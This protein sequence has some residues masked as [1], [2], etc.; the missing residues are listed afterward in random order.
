MSAWRAWGSALLAGS[1]LLL[2]ACSSPSD[3]TVDLTKAESSLQKFIKKQWFPSLDVGTVKCPTKKIPRSKGKVSTCTVK[4]ENEP[5][6]FRVVQTNGQ[7]GIAPVRYEAIL[8]TAKAEGIVRRRY[9]DIATVSCGDGPYFV[10]KPGTE[11]HCDVTATNGRQAQ[12]FYRVLDP[13]GNP[14]WLRNT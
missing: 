8:S 7:G 14:K 5:V 10:R 11:F 4:V 2:A 1:L 6:E 9:G 12:V 13:K 3:P